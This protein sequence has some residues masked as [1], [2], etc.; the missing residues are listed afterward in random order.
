MKTADNSF[1]T[2]TFAP[3]VESNETTAPTIPHTT[4]DRSNNETFSIRAYESTMKPSVVP[5]RNRNRIDREQ[6][7]N[8]IEIVE[9]IDLDVPDDADLAIASLVSIV[10]QMWSSATHASQEHQELLAI[11][12]SALLSRTNETLTPGH[13]RVFREVLLDLRRE[14]LTAAN[15]E[16][17]QSQFLDEGF[18]PLSPFTDV[19]I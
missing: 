6:L 19:D 8:A 13:V 3:D 9:G 18:G 2:A 10:G 15:V 4:D 17:V 14:E 5:E 12:E 11:L 16:V 1:S 7:E